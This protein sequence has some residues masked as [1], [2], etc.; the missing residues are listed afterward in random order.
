[1]KPSNHLGALLL[2]FA[3]VLA[4]WTFIP[5][6]D[7]LPDRMA[8]HFNAD[9][10][11]DGW[12]DKTRFRVTMIGTM[13]AIPLTIILITM[14]VRYLPDRL[15]NIPNRQFWLSADRR[16]ETYATILDFGMAAAGSTLWLFAMLYREVVRA[17]EAPGASFSPGWEVMTFP[18][19]ITALGLI[20]L[21]VKFRRA[22]ANA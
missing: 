4:A 6:I 7:H 3:V 5:S 19:L 20:R 1:M 2:F 11:A 18:M 9:G 14:L 10:R 16:D 21:V 22:P 8:T 15:L 17:N 12:T 13:L